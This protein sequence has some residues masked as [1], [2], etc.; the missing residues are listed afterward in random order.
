MYYGECMGKVEPR[1]HY[2]REDV[3][4]EIVDF[5]RNRWVSIEGY[6]GKDKVFTRYWRNGLP[7]T[8]NTGEHLRRIISTYP[9]TRT[10]YASINIYYEVK[11]RESVEIPDNIAFTTPFWDVDSK[12]EYWKKTLEASRVI[13]DFLEK[14]HVVKSVYLLWSGEG[15]H[16]RIHEKAFSPDLLSKHH[17]LDVAYAVVEY[18]LENTKN[19]LIA[20]SKEVNGALKVES[21]VDAKRVFTVPLSIH[22]RLDRVAVVFKPEQIDEFHVDWSL[23]ENYKHN[24]EWREY[25]EGEADEL[26]LKALEKIGELR[27]AEFRARQTRLAYTPITTTTG[28][29]GAIGRFQVMGLLQAARY[30]LLTG[31][32]EKAKSFGLNR[33]IFYA[34]AKY[35]GRTYKAK[36]PTTST[37][38]KPWRLVKV[39]GEEVPV[40]PR[41]WFMMG[42]V[43]QLP[44]DYD[45][46]I[47]LKINSIIRYEKAWKAALEYLKQFPET[48]LRDP[49]KFY[50]YVYEPVRDN[51]I[52]KVLKRKLMAKKTIRLDKFLNQENNSH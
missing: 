26:A 20:L 24:P 49:Q 28:G 10:I 19:K 9:W 23:P 7:L 27:I 35:Y 51:F 17:P 2:L 18:V 47:A 37:S 39:L 3:I 31:D 33:A 45:K 15:L 36:K 46:N 34:W 44:E 52:E 41:G 30:Y 1:I 43:E 12:I 40:S 25:V 11:T 38:G 16:V 4:R 5:A 13:V 22:R 42:D 48:I 50:K 8:I 14:N 32:L 6:R 29:K 21:L